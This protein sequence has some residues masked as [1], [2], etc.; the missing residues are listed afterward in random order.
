MIY[1]TLPN[2]YYYNKVNHIIY[3]L[4]KDHK[5]KLK[6]PKIVINTQ[7]GSIPYQC[8]NGDI[9]NNI[10]NGMFY[11]DLVR[12]RDS[13]EL[14]IRLNFANILLEDFDYYD[15][16]GHVALQIFEDTGVLIE[17]S[18][19]PFM[20]FLQEKYPSYDFML[21]KQADIIN[22]FDENIL[23]IL[24]DQ[25]C[26]QL[27]GLPDRMLFDLPLLKKLPQKHKLE[28]TLDPSCP[29]DCERYTSCVLAEQE[30]QLKYSGMSIFHDC[31]KC[32]F[33][34]DNPQLITMEQIQDIYLPLGFCHYTFSTNYRI[35]DE[36]F[37]LTFYIRYFFKQ[38]YWDELIEQGLA[39]LKEVK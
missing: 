29:I 4:S 30:N 7:S 37:Q 19:I 14:N 23:Q 26:F 13:G 8:W 31:M 2:F 28:L 32:F 16:L 1:F 39:M 21:S 6:N 33:K 5:L 3:G 12:F 27:I 15:N 34:E 20:E 9:N 38:E 25:D 11:S 22:P 10:G 36:V 35:I 18:S 17:I 24:T